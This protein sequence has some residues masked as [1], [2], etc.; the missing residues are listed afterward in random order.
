[1]R[2]VGINV[3]K[4]LGSLGIVRD[5]GNPKSLKKVKNPQSLRKVNLILDLK[6][7]LNRMKLNYQKKSMKIKIKA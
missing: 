1:M 6:V 3:E 4:N 5:L 7:I 2:R